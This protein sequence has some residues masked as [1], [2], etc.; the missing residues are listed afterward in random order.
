[1]NITPEIIVDRGIGA[2]IIFLPLTFDI[3]VDIDH[4]PQRFS[5]VD[6]LTNFLL[7]SIE[8]VVGAAKTDEEYSL[9]LIV[10][11]LDNNDALRIIIK[12]DTQLFGQRLVKTLDVGIFQI[13][14]QVGQCRFR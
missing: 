5:D 10:F 12:Y 9:C 8:N 14:T 1:M 4:A 3:A 7:L 11:S 2:E 6:V 13:L